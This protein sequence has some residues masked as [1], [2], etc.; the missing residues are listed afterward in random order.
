M[1]VFSFTRPH[2]RVL[3]EEAENTKIGISYLDGFVSKDGK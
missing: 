3:Q 2:Q 1:P